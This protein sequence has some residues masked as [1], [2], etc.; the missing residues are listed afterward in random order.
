MNDLRLL[1]QGFLDLA[2][3]STPALASAPAAEPSPLPASGP[4]SRPAAAAFAASA[5]VSQVLPP[6]PR[7]AGPPTDGSGTIR[8][9]IGAD[10][11]VKGASIEASLHPRYDL[12][13]LAAAWSWRYKP[14]TLNGEPVASE[15]L[16]TFQVETP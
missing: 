10:G 16:V 12:E 9:R 13:V 4:P 1:A 11:R 2:E 14:A 7:T 8:V 6:W 5:V 15:K 3:A